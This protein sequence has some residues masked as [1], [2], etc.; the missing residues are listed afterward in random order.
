MFNWG[1]IVVESINAKKL[2]LDVVDPI[3]QSNETKI[4][5]PLIV[6]LYLLVVLSKKYSS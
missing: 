1:A 2:E 4:L 3:V 6:S 5:P